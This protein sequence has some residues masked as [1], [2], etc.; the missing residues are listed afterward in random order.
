MT[1]LLADREHLSQRGRRIRP[2]F[3]LPE[4]L[5]V[6]LI[7]GI[8]TSLSVPRFQRALEQSRA[9]IAAANLRVIW[10][11]QRLYW[12]DNHRYTT[13]LSDLAPLLDPSILNSTVTYNYGLVSA[14]S[15]TFK[16]TATRNGATAW[17][18]TLTIDQTGT[19]TG[20]LQAPGQPI[21]VPG[22]Q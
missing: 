14:D 10:S 18:G 20:Q 6:I 1:K 3:S 7:I 2:G 9:D 8:L 15:T 13:N 12:L 17:S 11:A 4:I 19:I 21:I 16:A 22:F 5:C